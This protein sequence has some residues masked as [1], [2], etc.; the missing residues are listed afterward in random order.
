M[1]FVMDVMLWGIVP[2]PAALAEFAKLA[3]LVVTKVL[4]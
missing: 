4:L 1:G 2:A 3:E